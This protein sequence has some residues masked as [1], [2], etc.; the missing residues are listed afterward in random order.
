[1]RIKLENALTTH[2]K[3]R[4]NIGTGDFLET[5]LTKDKTAQLREY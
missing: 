5:V 3:K 2:E 4:I 1:M